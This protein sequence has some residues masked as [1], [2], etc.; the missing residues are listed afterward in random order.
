MAFREE[1]AKERLKFVDYW[2]DY[3]LSH[4][5]KVWSKQQNIIINLSLRSSN[6]TI[7]KYDKR[8]ISS[9]ERRI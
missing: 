2:S 9:H 5:D 4:E 6:M 1:N 3:V 8:G 7:V